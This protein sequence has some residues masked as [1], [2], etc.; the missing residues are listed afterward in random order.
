M[1]Q[2]PLVLGGSADLTPS[3]NTWFDGAEDFQKD[4][5]SGRYIRYG[6][7]EH[8]MGA[9]MNGIAV[10]ELV[11]PYGAT[12]L[13]FADYLRPAIRLAAMSHYPSIFVFTHDSIGVGEDGPTHQP[14][15]QISSLRAI[16]N[17]VVIRPG[18]A[19]ETVEAW[20]YAL[21]NCD[22]PVVMA[23]TRQSLPN[24]DQDKYPSAANLRKGAYVLIEQSEPD[25]LLIA[26][27]SEVQLALEACEVLWAEG[28][29]AQVVSMPSFEL[30]ERQDKSYQD[31][32]LPPTVRGRVAIEAGVESGWRKWI[33]ADGVFIGMSSFGASAPGARCFEEFGF[34]VDNVVKAAKKVKR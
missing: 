4:N 5:R 33:G 34:T 21:E 18:D 9:I 6:V 3:N 26:T 32:V 27:G 24:L 15:E 17:L 11:R 2:L 19:N 30:F 14:V 7:R 10:S 20:K 31:S 23:F 28:I 16:P 1:G 12:F 25:V 29:K 8:A 22:G 13:V